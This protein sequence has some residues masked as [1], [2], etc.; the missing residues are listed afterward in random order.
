MRVNSLYEIETAAASKVS[1]AQ[2]Y[3]AVSKPHDQSPDSTRK[4]PIQRPAVTKNY[5]ATKPRM[6][7]L[8]DIINETDYFILPA[9]ANNV[10]NHQSMARGA[11]NQHLVLCFHVCNEQRAKRKELRAK[12]SRE[13][14]DLAA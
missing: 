6:L 14:R 3:G 10:G 13:V 1:Q 12:G 7:V 8:S 4:L 11:P 2:P 5:R 9:K